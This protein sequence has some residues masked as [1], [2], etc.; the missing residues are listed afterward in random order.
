M[1]LLPA[2]ATGGMYNVCCHERTQYIC[3]LA[4]FVGVSCEIRIRSLLVQTAS[5][6]GLVRWYPSMK[7]QFV[8]DGILS[9]LVCL[10]Q[11]AKTVTFLGEFVLQEFSKVFSN[12]RFCC[13]K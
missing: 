10:K 3:C 9:K 13:H 7:Y 1:P 11:A 6:S 4:C 5:W 2:A 12:H 8:N